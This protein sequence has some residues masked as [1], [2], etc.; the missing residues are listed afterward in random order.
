MVKSQ[1]KINSKLREVL[2]LRG[3]TTLY[4]GY[5]L[6][7]LFVS[8]F[9]ISDCPVTYFVDHA[10]LERRDILL[11]LPPECWNQRHALLLP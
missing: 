2:K 6:L 9:S 7:R 11:P 3:I 10:G 4:E 1:G 8:L 5:T